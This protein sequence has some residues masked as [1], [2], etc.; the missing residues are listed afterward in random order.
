MKGEG[1]HHKKARG[2]RIKNYD[3]A[4]KIGPSKNEV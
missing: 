2:K 1:C 4:T 3:I